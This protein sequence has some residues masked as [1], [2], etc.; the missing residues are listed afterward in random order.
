MIH[1]SR[2]AATLLIFCGFV[3]AAQAQIL[4]SYTGGAGGLSS[5]TMSTG[6]QQYKASAF[7]VGSSQAS[8]TA[9][10]FYTNTG[11]SSVDYVVSLWA[12]TYTS[13]SAGQQALVG[14]PLATVTVNASDQSA[15]TL[16]TATFASAVTLD[17]NATYMLVFGYSPVTGTSTSLGVTA[18]GNESGVSVVTPLTGLFRSN[19]GGTAG[20]LKGTV[21]QTL[22]V[23][24]SL[25]GTVAPVPEPATYAVIAGLLA[26]GAVAW[27]RRRG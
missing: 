11:S 23:A 16:A 20:N 14:S 1:A 18:F 6:T 10:N 19:A 17:A 5:N 2:L 4:I 24:Y 7:T 9:V 12:A 25:Q 15:L 13:S 22:S 21:D 8:V 3:C 27:R 26:L